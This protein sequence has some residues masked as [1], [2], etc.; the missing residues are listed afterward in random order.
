L[1]YTYSP[2]GNGYNDRIEL[3]ANLEGI[4][5][6]NEAIGGGPARVTFEYGTD[7]I[8]RD[9][10]KKQKWATGESATLSYPSMTTATVTDVLGQER[11]YTIGTNDPNDASAD[12]THISELREPAVPVWTAA[13]FGN[14]PGSLTAGAP[15]VSAQER[16]WTFGYTEG[17]QTSVKLDGVSQTTT[18]YKTAPG[19]AGKIIFNTSTGPDGG[20]PSA[21]PPWM[22]TD[23]IISSTFDY[24]TGPNAAAFLKGII[25]GDKRIVSP[26][27]HR[28]APSI[29]SSN[30][31]VTE[32]TRYEKSGLPRESNSSGGTDE[33]G[34]SAGAKSNIEYYG[35]TAAKHARYQPQ[36]IH[37]GEGASRLTTT[38]EYPTELKT[39][40]TDP[41]GVKTT[42]ELDA[43]R[44]PVKVT[45]K[46]PDDPL[47]ME[48]RHEYD[49]TGRTKK[50]IQRQGATDVTTSYE[51]DVMG[52]RKSTSTDNVATVGT[53]TTTV[54]YDLA[55]H[56]TVTTHPG[57]AITTTIVD[58]LGRPTATTVTTGSSPIEQ[59]FA[60]DL[61]GNR[62][63]TTDMLTATASAYD[64]HGRMIATRNSDGT[65]TTT[66]HDDLGNSTEVKTLDPAATETVSES[67]YTFTTGGRLESV[68]AKV[69]VGIVRTT[70]MVWDGAGRTTGTATGN[71][72]SRSTFDLAGRATMHAS[73]AGSATVLSEIFS[74]TE[75][76][77]NDGDLPA[78][79]K[80]SEKG[81]PEITTTLDRDTAGNVT[82]ATTGS[83]EWKQKYD[84]LGHVTEASAPGRP[85]TQW[86]VDARGAVEKE[87]LPDGAANNY[88]YH[89]SGAQSGYTDPTAEATGTVNDL[90][91]RPMRRTYPDGTSETFTW[92]GA[93]L[94]SVT[95]RQGRA[96]TYVYNG[97]G[98]LSE[99]HGSAGVLDRI[100]YDEAGRMASWLTA[101]SEMKWDEFDL[102]GRPKKT[103]QRRFANGS[104]LTAS[105][106]LL[107]EFEQRHTYNEHGERTFASMPSYSGLTLAPGWSKGIAESHDA[108]GNV[109]TIARVAAPGASGPSI[110]TATY[111]NAGRPDTRTV[112]TAGGSM[113]LRQY[114]Y[115]TTTA[116]LKSV[117]VSNANGVIAGAEV[118]YNG[119][120]T[121]SAKL[122][123]IASGER[124]M[125]FGYDDRSRLLASL[126]GVK[127]PNADATAASIPGR[128]KEALNPADF[129]NAQERTPQLDAPTRMAL[130]SK[131]IDPARV[132]PPSSTYSERSGH[133]IAEMT[134][135]AQVR[136]FEYQGAE[137]IDDGQF[138]YE[139]DVKG[140]L[141]RATQKAT[142]GPIRSM[143]YTYSGMGRLVGRRAEYAPSS[144]SPVWQLEDRPQILSAD[145]LPAETTFVWDPITDRLVSIFK[146][147]ATVTTDAH[148]GLLK[149]IIHGDAAYDDPLE[150]ATIDPSTGQVTHLYPIYDE[151]ATGSLQAIVNT[152]GEVIARNLSQ[153]PY[154]ADDVALTGAAVDGVTVEIK[155]VAGSI[156]SVTVRMHSTEVLSS[157]TVAAGAR[158]A[159]VDQAG[160]VVRTSTVA[161]TLDP[162]DPFAVRWSLTSAE[163][164]TLTDPSPA[165]VA[166]TTL[167]PA[168][169]SVAATATLRATNWSSM[170]PLLPPPDWI[171]A[172]KPV[173]TSATLPVE[174]REPLA[175]LVTFTTMIGIDE[176]KTI[177][178]YEIDT[179]AL[180][181]NPGG[182]EELNEAIVSARMHAHPFTEPMTGLN[183]VRHRW[184]D[185][186]TATFLSPDPLGYQDSP[187]LYAFAGGDPINGRDPTGMYEEDVHRH[188]TVFLALKAGFR[189]DVAMRLGAETQALDLDSSDAMYGGGANNPNMESY[190]F[191][192]PRRLL[193]MRKTALEG[194][195]LDDARL[196]VVG[197]FLHAWED[198]YSHQA[199]NTRRDFSQQFHDRH[200]VTGQDI[201][202]GRKKHE[203]DWT[204][205]KRR[206]LSMAMAEATYY[207][208]V[209]L[210]ETYKNQCTGRREAL[211]KTKCKSSSNIRRKSMMTCSKLERSASRCRMS[212][213]TRKKFGYSA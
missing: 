211:S 59:R 95:D 212:C 179:L 46:D 44:R 74:K 131:G 12:R 20:S 118:A 213:R 67:S 77:V 110:M 37:Q 175:S 75:I 128:A 36:Y 65:I 168:A 14:L 58:A 42:T 209:A 53:V 203:P 154:G 149:Q 205:G 84:Q 117:M 96:Q 100:T 62:V 30:D 197:E 139:F 105:A 130:S 189:M 210:C 169:L 104:G 196:R 200:P 114:G 156:D 204:W 120:Q 161:P 66:K 86:A 121:A 111:R 21:A 109:A 125:L 141:A 195:V 133:K 9:R 101:D 78:V 162:T 17:M 207:Q 22:P 107:D 190:H 170:L 148:G 97:K 40:V 99:I 11:R 5:D 208:M 138:A 201:G 158:L 115:D 24:Q 41:R 144:S 145:G 50:A 73:G 119:L 166:A 55:N 142:V 171:Q 108:M 152:N 13:S 25:T 94:K 127:N 157:S 137:R 54:A 146:A 163:W 173:F 177:K 124:Y 8:E 134:K 19:G 167:R 43:W 3:Q 159:T 80:S 69:D 15:Q 57:G 10:V 68:K 112:T 116:Q 38:Y 192:S 98:Q 165:T 176:T 16:V 147:G 106:E 160:A 45:V 113:I 103:T 60:Y 83:L 126:Y 70:S 72:A 181:G 180:L 182:A 4:T 102:E 64:S 82:K 191:V 193:D 185:P 194:G 90:I 123:G 49:A 140:R 27:A 33:G 184:L 174:I 93:R 52:R 31:N 76:A 186:S 153:D 89:G 51:Y 34:E 56:R 1:K 32:T 188:L 26:E 206:R 61:A 122:L 85:A 136:S 132:E 35:D 29:E 198:S 39:I 81:G 2:V 178:L 79:T 164:S 87:T 91:G 135:G 7:A 183:Y 92:E 172:T 202:H 48:R 187:T 199:D 150:T 155:K 28:N 71:R 151:A 23:P 6:P 18:S 47:V 88:A 129:R 143:S 63:Y